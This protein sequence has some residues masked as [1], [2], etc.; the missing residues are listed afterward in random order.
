MDIRIVPGQLKGTVAAPV[1]KSELHRYLICAAFSDG[2]TVV[3]GTGDLLPDD[4]KATLSCLEKMG[5]SFRVENGSITAFPADRLPEDPALDCGGSGSTLRFLLPVA[6]ALCP[7]ALFTG[8]GSLEARPVRELLQALEQN[9][10]RFST[11]Q[12]PLV[13]ET[14][15]KNYDFTIPGNISSQYVSGLL[16]AGAVSPAGADITLTSKL[17]SA[18]YVDMTIDAL[19]RFG[20]KV[21]SDNGSYHVRGPLR[22]PG[23]VTVNGSWSAAA[24]ILAA[25][26][27]SG[28]SDVT[29][30]GLDTASVQS[31][32]AIL[33]ILIDMGADISVT[34]DSI[35]FTGSRLHGTDID[36]DGIPDLFPVLAALSAGAEGS[37][38]FRNASRLRY[39]ESDRLDSMYKLMSALGASCSESSDRFEI[40]YSAG[41]QGGEADAYGDH[42][43]VMAAAVAAY[44]L[45]A[46]VTVHG[47]EYVSKSYPGFFDDLRALGGG[48][49]VI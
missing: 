7:R 18:G 37:S 4:I 33:D 49:Y 47:A 45:R 35:R 27:A 29:V 5:A 2:P 43:I 20:A 32:R 31:D 21:I 17:G 44:A 11:E 23:T 38:V 22:S 24:G 40:T 10:T 12:L 48:I 9:G 25:A 3:D 28:G 6:A 41:A 13:M 46:E 39:K 42:R 1:S 19:R 15:L 14:G 30:T 34:G 26:A 8:S 36:V 16:M